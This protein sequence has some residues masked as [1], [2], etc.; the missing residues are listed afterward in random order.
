MTDLIYKKITTHNYTGLALVD[1]RCKI[2]I[3]VLSGLFCYFL[4]GEI[5]GFLLVLL[6]GAIISTSGLWG[7]A[8]K[9]LLCYTAIFCFNNLLGYIFIPFI[10]AFVTVFGVA[11]LKVL[12]IYMFGKW[13]LLTTPMDD[14]MIALQKM[15]LPQSVTISLTVMFRYIPTLAIE[16][17]II[18]N[19]MEIR[20]ICNTWFKKIIHPIQSIEFILIPLMMRCLKVTD[21]LAASGVTRGLEI[22]GERYAIN[23]IKFMPR[24][25]FV[26]I[27]VLLLLTTIALAD[28]LFLSE[29]EI[30]RWIL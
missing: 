24:D 9:M 7:F 14:F 23:P 21:E 11:L 4:S 15:K 18:R 16:Y 8:L 28:N 6:L 25:Y 26:C 12:P 20:G 17:R 1:P 5:S 30:L 22:E 19:A 2:I 27:T 13:M 29:I 3:L 10:S